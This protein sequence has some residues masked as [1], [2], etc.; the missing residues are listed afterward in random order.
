C[1]VGEVFGQLAAVERVASWILA[2]SNY[3]CDPQIVV[4]SL[5]M[6]CIHDYLVGRVV[7]SA[8]AGQRVSGSIPWSGKVLLSFFGFLKISVV[9][10]SLGKA[11][12][13]IPGTFPDSVLLLRNFRKTEKGSAILARPGNRTRPLPGSRT[14][15]HSTN[16]ADFLLLLLTANRKLLKA[17]PPLTSVT[18]DHHGVQCFKN[19]VK[20]LILPT[21]IP[22]YDYAAYHSLPRIT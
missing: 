19:L 11:Y 8:I 4:S 20:I 21:Y 7:A 18:G 6:L 3:L 13:H 2:P 14:C 5:A 1:T 9:P 22:L 16:E 15:N 17:N 10:R 12:C